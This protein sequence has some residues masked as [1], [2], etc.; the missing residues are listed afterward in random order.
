MQISFYNK[1]AVVALVLALIALGAA[2]LWPSHGDGSSAKKETA[3]ERVMRT[4]TLR[5]SYISRAHHFTI[6]AAAKKTSG[7]DYEVMEALGKLTGLKIDWVEETGVGAFPELLSSGKVD[8]HCV[9]MWTNVARSTRV[10]ATG[11]VLYTPVYAYVRAGDTR[12][13]GNIAALNGENM[14]I[15]VADSGTMKAI[16]DATFP[17]A[18]QFALTG[19]ST[20]AELLLNVATR[21]ADATFADELAVYD[22]NKNNPD[23]QLKRVA[24]VVPLRTYSEAFD[25]AM[26]EWE[27]REVLSTAVNELHNNGTIDRILGKYEN[28]PGEIM[29]VAMPYAGGQKL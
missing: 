25:V 9:T 23:K 3:F 19:L 18:R 8:A 24:G 28:V 5:C 27:L 21:K 6:D 15:S 12:F 13:D 16:A 20:E 14:I 17:K 1:I 10:I 4:R 7:I 29:R 11:P 26:G 22:Y 2:V